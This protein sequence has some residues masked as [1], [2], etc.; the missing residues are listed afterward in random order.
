VDFLRRHILHNI[1][2]KLL[3]LAIAV[4]LWMAVAR[5]P[6][7]EVAI[8]VPIEFT[9]APDD[10]EISSETIPQVQVR[11]RG[12]ANTVHV[13]GPAEVHAVIDLRSASPGEHTYDL[14]PNKIR[15]PRDVE[16]IQVIPSQFRISFDKRGNKKVPVKPRVIGASA[17]GFR[18]G[19]VKVEPEYV[20]I[21]G[22]EQRVNAVESVI[23]D[24]VDASGVMG[25]AT[26]ST[27]VY[28]SDP[29]VRLTSPS[30]VRVT[31]TTEPRGHSGH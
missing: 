19:D 31:V 21:A 14:S 5:E 18:L 23:T 30:T 9:N 29:L 13:L 4:L 24:P 27:H 10:L 11:E 1:G 17:P 2:L 8:T 7:A 16:T 6:K 12:P 20:N 26:F 28:V 3:S 15:A 25:S 22:P